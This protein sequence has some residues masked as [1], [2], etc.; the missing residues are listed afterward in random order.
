MAVTGSACHVC[1]SLT[2]KDIRAQL[3]LEQGGSVGD[4][5]V[6]HVKSTGALPVLYLNLQAV[7]RSVREPLFLRPGS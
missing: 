2:L 1:K 3:A 6:G 5:P 7:A 4:P